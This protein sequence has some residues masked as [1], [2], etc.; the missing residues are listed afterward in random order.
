MLIESITLAQRDNKELEALIY[1][2]RPLIRKCGRQLHI[3]DGEQE[4]V[5]AFI[6]LIKRF[7]PERLRS[8][9]DGKVVQYI[10]NAMNYSCFK[11]YKKHH[12][13]IATII[14]LEEIT[15]KE[16]AAYL[17]G[18]DQ[19][20]DMQL[21]QTFQL[22]LLTEKERIHIRKDEQQRMLTVWR[23]PEKD[24]DEIRDCFPIGEPLLKKVD[25]DAGGG[26][27]QQVISRDMEI[28]CNHF[29]F[30]QIRKMSTVFVIG[31]CTR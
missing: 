27:S 29:Q 10:K 28:V 13:P 5:V 15:V 22:D 30:V 1:R 7:R 14:S 25:W 4:M 16:E 3:E 17:T 18:S 31:Y 20:Q 21:D 24:A 12:N 23:E 2:F 8:Q 6:E 19:S 9:D 11:I 26:A